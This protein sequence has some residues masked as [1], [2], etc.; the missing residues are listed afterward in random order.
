L[1]I[2]GAC[3]VWV[4]RRSHH[5]Y[6]SGLQLFDIAYS[7]DESENEIKCVWNELMRDIYRRTKF[8]FEFK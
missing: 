7:G 3:E 1:E 5:I 6:K 4:F 8:I 2:V